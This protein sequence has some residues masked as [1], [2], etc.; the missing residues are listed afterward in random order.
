MKLQTAIPLPK[1]QHNL[2]DYHSQLLLLGSCFSE[3]IGD[4]FAHHKFESLSNPLGILFHPLAIETLISRAINLDY[5]KADEVQFYNEQ[6]F[7]LDAHSKL[8]RTHKADLLAE[9]NAQID[10]TEKALR[11]SS[12][13]VITLG[14]SWVYRHIASD[15]VVA[16]CHKLPQKQFLKELLPVSQISESLSAIVSLAKSVNPKVSFIFTV[17]PVR[18]IKDGFVENTQGKSHLIAAIHEVVD[19]R[20]QQYYFPSFEIMMDELRDYR[21]YGRDL[22][23][24]NALAVDYIWE[25]FKS[26]WLTDEA[27]KT[28][29]T[30]AS[31]QKGLQHRPF[32]AESEAHQKFIQNLETKIQKLQEKF[33]KL[34]F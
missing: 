4:K 13:V 26:V 20:A 7:C 15:A 27:I 8:N 6:W 14:T 17:S 11:S 28:A 16:N 3:N 33:P 19:P 18:H 30:V 10:A 5:Y 2:I 31:V 32:N 25:K 12:H 22:L 23:H 34:S 21:F 29:E 9:L 1:Q 24:P